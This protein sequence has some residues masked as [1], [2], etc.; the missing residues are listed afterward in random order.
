MEIQHWLLTNK[1]E[2]K[3]VLLGISELVESLQSSSDM[4]I[5]TVLVA[6]GLF[7]AGGFQ[8]QSSAPAV[9]A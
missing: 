7:G 4:L 2:C 3:G 6:A 9:Y 5:V 1:Q 8:C